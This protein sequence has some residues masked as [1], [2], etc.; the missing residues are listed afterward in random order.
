MHTYKGHTSINT[1]C[2]LGGLRAA[3]AQVA[4]L[5]DDTPIRHTKNDANRPKSY[6]LIEELEIAPWDGEVQ[7]EENTPG[8]VK[9]LFL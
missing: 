3:L 7:C 5:P 9:A 2:T 4:D 1:L 6:A 8:A